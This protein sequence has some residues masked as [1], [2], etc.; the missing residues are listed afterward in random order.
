[1]TEV[2]YDIEKSENKRSPCGILTDL[3]RKDEK[4]WIVDLLKLGV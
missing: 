2:N 3:N 1:V 4:S